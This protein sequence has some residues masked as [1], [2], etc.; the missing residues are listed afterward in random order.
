MGKRPSHALIWLDY[1][2]PK[3]FSRRSRSLLRHASR[4]RLR[5][6]ISFARCCLDERGQALAEL[7]LV[8]VLVCVLAL[9]L[10]QPLVYLY[11]KMAL[12]QIAAELTRVVA[13]E[14]G[15]PSGSREILLKSYVAD[16]LESLPQ[17]SAFRVP[18][19]LRVTV[20]GDAHSERIEVQVSVKQK[21]LPL[22]GLLTGAGINGDI[23]VTGRAAGTGAWVGVEG[24]PQSAP[25]VFGKID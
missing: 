16:K 8:I 25:Q 5:R 15:A 2:P 7:P 13:T 12:G 4:L 17:G 1:F 11:T 3:P 20:S 21:P 19:T 24:S 22:M 10:I 14:E 6:K 9:M 18:G 23:E